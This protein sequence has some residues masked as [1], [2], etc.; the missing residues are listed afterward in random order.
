MLRWLNEAAKALICSLVISSIS[1][2]QPGPP[3]Q[4]NPHLQWDEMI[5]ISIPIGDRVVEKAVLVI[6]AAIN[7]LHRPALMQ[8][9]LGTNQTV[10]YGVPYRALGGT[11][12][13]SPEG[14][15]SIDGAI[16]GLKVQAESIRLDRNSGAEPRSGEPVEL[17]T[18]GASFFDERFLVLD[19]VRDKIAIG[20]KSQPLPESMERLAGFAP[21]Q[22][23][24]GKAFVSL[25][26]GDK[27]ESGFFYDTG[28]SA[29]PLVTTRGRW[30]EFTQRRPEDPGNEIW[31]VSSWGNDAALVGARLPTALCV[32]G[33]CIDSPLIYFE[34]SGLENLQ[35][36][37]YGYPAS[38]L[39]GNAI[40]VNEYSVI[41]DL[42]AQRLGL[43][44]GSLSDP[45]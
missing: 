13:E 37:K 43:M 29:L 32:G 25:R 42:A 17:G 40:F 3:E 4:D 16:A 26:I 19:F 2:A 23:R 33:A 24:N 38:G 14:R 22:Y 9:D 15:I 11:A 35:F 10:L 6:N 28:S 7:G 39:I 45:D 18:V 41:I 1:L 8:L 12:E 20:A 21:L 31:Q 34:R 44:K 30:L 5:W 36:D 27:E